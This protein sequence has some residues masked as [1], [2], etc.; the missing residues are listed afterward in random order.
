M[1]TLDELDALL[2]RCET[3]ARRWRSSARASWAIGHGFGDPSLRSI[4][5]V[6]ATSG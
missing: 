6:R 4:S 5:R 1:K 2:G 3:I